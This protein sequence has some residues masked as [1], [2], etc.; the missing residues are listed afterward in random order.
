MDG[1]FR[2]CEGILQ[3]DHMKSTLI[4]SM[5]FQTAVLKRQPILL[6]LLL[7]IKKIG[8]AFLE[9]KIRKFTVI[10]A[11]LIVTQK[12]N[13]NSTSWAKDTNQQ[14][15]LLLVTNQEKYHFLYQHLVSIVPHAISQRKKNIITV[16]HAK[17]IQH[18]RLLISSI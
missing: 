17:F 11:I 14:H 10:F 6:K 7:A 4:T 8:R 15:H 9:E 5:R 12:L 3:Q 16:M 18:L 2:P 1:R 13:S